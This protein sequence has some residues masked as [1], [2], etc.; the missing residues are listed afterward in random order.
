ML[1][2]CILFDVVIDSDSFID[3]IAPVVVGLIF[4]IYVVDCYVVYLCIT[5]PVW[6][7]C[8]SC[9]CGDLLRHSVDSPSRTV[10]R[11]HVIRLI[12]YTVIRLC[13]QLPF[14][15][16]LLL[17]V[18]CCL[19]LT[20]PGSSAAPVTLPALRSYDVYSCSYVNTRY[21]VTFPAG[22]DDLLFFPTASRL[23]ASI[24][25]NSGC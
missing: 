3:C 19:L 22:P 20:I 12:V 13:S 9:H 16:D 15:G 7:R 10:E 5:A 18:G 6:L 4:P 17:V 25:I 1:Q 2:H 14:V 8:D 24:P 23:R 11:S 21:V